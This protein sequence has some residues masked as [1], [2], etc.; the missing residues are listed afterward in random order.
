MFL[1][2]VGSFYL[3]DF[4]PH[5][6]MGRKCLKWHASPRRADKSMDHAE[7]CAGQRRHG[8][9]KKEMLGQVGDRAGKNSKALQN[10]EN[11]KSEKIPLRVKRKRHSW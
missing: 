8:E 2:Y 6:L 1:H 5:H 10:Q 3:L 9:A 11:E 7:H 4:R